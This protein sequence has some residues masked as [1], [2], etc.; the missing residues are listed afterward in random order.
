MTRTHTGCEPSIALQDIVCHH[1]CIV[2]RSVISPFDLIKIIL[3]KRQTRQVDR[4][5]AWNPHSE[6]D[7][8]STAVDSQSPFLLESKTNLKLKSSTAR[9]LHRRSRP[10]A[11]N[12]SELEQLALDVRAEKQVWKEAS[13]RVSYNFPFIPL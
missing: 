8:P 9:K 3:I 1:Y 11:A 7:T 10:V 2:A 4:K 12:A 13:Q 6:G 5:W